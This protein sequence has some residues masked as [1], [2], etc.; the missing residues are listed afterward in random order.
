M[1]RYRKGHVAGA[2]LSLALAA[3]MLGASPASAHD[4]LIA[5]TPAAGDTVVS[6]T[7]VTLTFSGDLLGGGDGANITQVIGPDQRHY[8]LE[9]AAVAGPALTTPVALGAPGTYE[10]G[11]RAVSSDGH[12]ISGVLTFEY[13][14]DA[15]QQAAAGSTA[16]PCADIRAVDAP[17][18]ESPTADVPATDGTG[19]VTGF[20]IGGAGIVAVGVVVVLILRRPKG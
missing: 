2:G 20:V 6:L 17:E 10:I 18:T 14:P 12:P 8:E 3:V 16:S 15:G 1:T 13:A 5:A 7:A 19:V 4:S 11:W 9:C